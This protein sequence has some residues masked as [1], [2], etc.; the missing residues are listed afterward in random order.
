M[1]HKHGNRILGRRAHHRTALLKNLSSELLLHGSIV[2]STAKGKELKRW[3]E[4]L[5]TA[6]K[7]ESTL[8]RRRYLR[9]RVQASVDVTRLLAVAKASENRP[10]GYLR[11]TKLPIQRSD[12]AARVRVDIIDEPAV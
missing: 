3:L 4:P 9:Q 1:K 12:A 2:T 11:L 10:G 5:V 7:G 8:S 6:A